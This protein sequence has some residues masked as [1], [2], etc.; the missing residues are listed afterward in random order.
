M[1]IFPPAW[2]WLH[3]GTKPIETPKYFMGTYLH[4][5]E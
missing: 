1:V 5:V 4:Y 2:P 3:R